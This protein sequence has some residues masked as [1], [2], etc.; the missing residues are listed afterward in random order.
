MGRKIKF[1][2]SEQDASNIFNT[3]L[4]SICIGDSEDK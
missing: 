3:L 1:F 4:N 2:H